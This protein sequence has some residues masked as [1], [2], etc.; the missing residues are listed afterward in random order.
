MIRHCPAERLRVWAVPRSSGEAPDFAVN[1]SML[2]GAELEA[3]VVKRLRFTATRMR[4]IW[5]CWERSDQPGLHCLAWERVGHV[6]WEGEDI[7][8]VDE[9]DQQSA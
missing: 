4:D 1:S 3:S 2:N 6:A 9:P 8:A 5:R 7:G